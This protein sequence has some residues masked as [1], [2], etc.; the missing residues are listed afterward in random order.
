MFELY[1][2]CANRKHVETICSSYLRG[3]E[4]T[5]LSITGHMYFV[6]RTYMDGVVADVRQFLILV[7][8]PV[9]RLLHQFSGEDAYTK[10]TWNPAYKGVDDYLLS[11][12]AGA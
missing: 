3:L 8:L 5:K 2:I 9:Q 7:G 11:C 4:A 1:Q 6:P 12:A 10:Y